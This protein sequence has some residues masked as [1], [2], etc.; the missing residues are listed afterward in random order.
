MAIK[1]FNTLVR[2]KEEFSPAAPPEVSLYVCGPT[3]YDFIH[4]GNARVFIIFDVIRRYLA[5]RGYKV[6]MIQNYTDIDD[7][8]INRAAKQGLLVSELARRYIDAYQ[9]DAGALRVKPADVHP[10]ATEHISQIISLIRHLEEKKIAYASD[11]DV[12]FDTSGFA[13]Y[14]SLSRQNQDELLAGARVEPGD[15]K[16]HPLDFALWKQKKPGEPFWDS[17]WGEG[18]PGWHVECSAMAMHYLGETIDIHAGGNDLIFPHH[19]NEIAQ[20]SAASGKPFARYWLHAGYLNFNDQKMS[21][22]LGNV[23]T[24]RSLLEQYKP[25]D[26]RFFILSAHYRSPLNFSQELLG[27]ACSGRERLQEMID[28]LLIALNA[29]ASAVA[30]ASGL[31]ASRADASDSTVGAV[32]AAD[33]EITLEIT[34]EQ[35]R[36]NFLTAMDDDFN[37]ADAIAELFRLARVC[38]IYLQKGYPYR[39]ALLEKVLSFYREADSILEILDLNLPHLLDPSIA[40]LIGKRDQARKRRDWAAA[41]RIREELLANGIVL[42]DTAHGTRWKRV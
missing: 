1:I 6:K 7:K 9:E 21:K 28:N 13:A 4:I 19:E 3:V 20:S 18:R 14:G 36:H 37:T 31:P 27:Q 11:G 8:M 22:S 42:E 17:P 30:A 10:L 34:S 35:V 40:E 26:L 5:F 39:K 23:T 12:Y 24:V 41:D 16:R 15:K 32:T 2:R 33:P 25:L 38:N 29:A